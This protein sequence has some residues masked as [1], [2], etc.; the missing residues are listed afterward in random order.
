VP[1]R[2]TIG[3]PTPETTAEDVLAL[4]DLADALGVR[5]WLDGGWAV[6]ACLGEQTR[7]HAD[8]DIVVTESEVAALVAALCEKGYRALP[9][10]DT[11]PWNFVL[12]DPYGRDIDFH[13]VVLDDGGNAIYGPPENGDRYPATALDGTGAIT[14]RAVACVTPEQQV[15]FH[16]G[17]PVDEDDWADV[18]RLCARFGI[19]VP[20][21]YAR[22][23]ARDRTDDDE[24][25]GASERGSSAGTGDV[26]P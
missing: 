17:Y 4:L 23:V 6:D 11:R 18:S 7:K 3:V 13:V 1:V 8:V 24:R 15:I 16:T 25:I 5:I 12:G 26:V 20:D 19:P 10:S 22:F 14:G 21:D 9:R 2:E